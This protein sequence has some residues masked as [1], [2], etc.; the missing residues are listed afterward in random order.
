VNIVVAGKSNVDF[1]KG[2]EDARNFSNRTL[3]FHA[4]TIR[5]P[6]IRYSFYVKEVWLV[7]AR[8]SR[9]TQKVL[10][11][12]SV[13]TCV[14]R[15]TWRFRDHSQ[16]GRKPPTYPFSQTGRNFSNKPKPHPLTDFNVH[17]PENT[18]TRLKPFL[19][20]QTSHIKESLWAEDQQIALQ[21][22]CDSILTSLSSRLDSNRSEGPV[23]SMKSVRFGECDVRSYPQVLGDHPYC[24]VGCPLELGWEYECIKHVSVDDYEVQRSE[25]G[26][27]P[28]AELKLSPQERRDILAAYT[29][30]EI[31]RACRRMNRFGT[32]K[33]V[34]REFFATAKVHGT[35]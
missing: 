17:K 35:V 34:Q 14:P 19:S 31:R 8:R 24:S 25:R 7:L 32:Q 28:S 5:L 18:T 6:R 30:A 29:D 15:L 12:E 33:R 1:G 26:S 3:Q 23:M 20:L 13:V 22:S 10:A 16:S 11:V 4:T 21:N 27:R 9:P 2:H